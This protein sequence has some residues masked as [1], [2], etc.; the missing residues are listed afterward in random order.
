VTELPKPPPDRSINPAFLLVVDVQKGFVTAASQHVLPSIEN[1]QSRFDTVLYARFVNPDPSPFRSILRYDKMGR[2]TPD[3]EFAIEPCD[4]SAVMEHTAYSC[5]TGELLYWLRDRD[6]KDVCVCGIATEACVLKTVMDLFEYHFT[7][8]VLTDLCA[9]D[10]NDRFH[11]MAVEV[12]GALIG[13]DHLIETK[14]LK[15]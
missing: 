13:Q 6:V 2:G 14:T 15:P 9:S 5:V 8:W 12:V 7:P 4:G 1:V 10:K 3:T 11:K